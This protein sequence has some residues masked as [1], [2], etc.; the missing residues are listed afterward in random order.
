MFSLCLFKK[1]WLN[2]DYQWPNL[3]VEFKQVNFQFPTKILT[4]DDIF[5]LQDP[6]TAFC[7]ISTH[8]SKAKLTSILLG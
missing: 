1:S 2:I 6:I 5:T 7:S 3:V 4:D 8:R